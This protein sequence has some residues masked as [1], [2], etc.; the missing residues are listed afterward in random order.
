MDIIFMRN[1]LIYF[2][3]QT[4]KAILGKLRQLLKPDGY[5]FTDSGETTLNL[6]D[7]FERVQFNK[8]V[9]YKLQIK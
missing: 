7:L 8:S 4:K 9:C 2:D 3:T 6:D 1:V 5:L